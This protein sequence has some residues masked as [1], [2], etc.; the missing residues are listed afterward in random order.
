MKIISA[1]MVSLVL[2]SVLLLP[3]CAPQGGE[4]EEE[5]EYDLEVTYYTYSASGCWTMPDFANT[6]ID[7]VRIYAAPKKGGVRQGNVPVAFEITSGPHKLSNLAPGESYEI[8][9][10]VYACAGEAPSALMSEHW[11]REKVYSDS[12]PPKKYCMSDCNGNFAQFEYG[13]GIKAGTDTIEVSAEIDGQKLEKTVTITWQYAE[14]TCVLDLINNTLSPANDVV[15]P[16]APLG[17]GQAV[18]KIDMGAA[19]S[20][21]LE[22]RIKVADPLANPAGPWLLNIGNSPSNNGAGG[23]GGHFSNDSELDITIEGFDSTLRVYANGYYATPGAVVF[24][25]TDLFPPPLAY[26]EHILR[27]KIADQK[28]RALVEG[29]PDSGD[30]SNP[31]IFRLGGSDAEAG[32]NDFIYYAAFDR[33]IG[34][35]TRIGSGV[36]GVTFMWRTV[37][38]GP[39]WAIP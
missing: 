22:M 3:S 32:T 2:L 6:I 11:K 9:E 23:D 8:G 5:E 24:D 33:V 10:W 21:V 4:Q 13:P 36:T 16:V 14:N 12:R 28:M 19:D 30:F 37:W 27:M 15:T 31:Y 38:T 39:D 18:V 26:Y 7:T 25:L 35:P 29:G 20:S 17:D 34:S 1:L